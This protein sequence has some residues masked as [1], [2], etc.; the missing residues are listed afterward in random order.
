MLSRRSPVSSL[1]T[2]LVLALGE[3]YAITFFGLAYFPVTHPLPYPDPASLFSYNELSSQ[4]SGVSLRDVNELQRRVIAAASLGA[5]RYRRSSMLG[6]RGLDEVRIAEVSEG[7]FPALAVTPLLGNGF[8]QVNFSAG[9]DRELLIGVRFWKSR[10]G[11][12]RDVLGSTVD[13]G[14]KP[15]R[16]VGVIDAGSLFGSVEAWL[17]A[18]ESRDQKVLDDRSYGVIGRLKRGASLAAAQSQ[19]ERTVR[20]L[21]GNLPLLN[22]DWR[23]RIVRLDDEVAEPARRSTMMLAATSFALYL[24]SLSNAAVHM[25]GRTIE[26]ERETAIRIVLGLSLRVELARQFLRFI[27]ESA[28]GTAIALTGYL[29]MHNWLLARVPEAFSQIDQTVRLGS[30][31]GFA[32]GLCLF[33]AAFISVL[34]LLRVAAL[35]PFAVLQRRSAH[36]T[37]RGN[38]QLNSI[39]VAVQCASTVVLL[40][41]AGLMGKSAWI[42]EHQRLGFDGR[43]V[44]LARISAEGEGD[45]A[46]AA[47]AEAY[48]AALQRLGADRRFL[49][50]GASSD[51][52]LGGTDRHVVSCSLD[53]IHECEDSIYSSVSESYLQ[54]L[55]LKVSAGRPFSPDDVAAASPVAM[56][57]ASAAAKLFPGGTSVGSGISI[58]GETMRV[59]GVVPDV[60]RLGVLGYESRAALQ[61]Y[62]LHRDTASH[63]GAL[64][65]IAVR[66]DMEP[67]ET[68]MALQKDLAG[69]L[70]GARIARTRSLADLLGSV[71]LQSRKFASLL[72]LCVLFAGATTLAGVS[73]VTLLVVQGERKSAGIRL[74]FGAPQCRVV[75]GVLRPL[76]IAFVIGTALG[77]GAGYGLARL[78]ENL[79]YGVEVRD[80]AVFTILPFAFLSIATLIS[81]APARWLA[82]QDLTDLLRSE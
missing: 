66:S 70:G 39:L 16:I 59:I 11:Q 4:G 23:P 61:V 37:A 7:F 27:F 47:V 2:C 50:V 17:P 65:V 13:L 30:L 18:V 38:G 79:L 55:G 28:A 3:L 68:A 48:S 15:A 80:R 74:A 75:A 33:A 31:L 73:S 10:F 52:P 58:A 63:L 82:R 24:L 36:A 21:E 49:S 42:I 76:L 44:V 77:V 64:S 9:S 78:L 72:G 53:G 60:A 56:I 32:A 51:Y 25:L 46:S 5:Y 35:D 81:L 8:R 20:D 40:I 29:A 62:S 69:A 1:L 26:W 12:S 45:S 67:A 6:A 57:S 71:G 41:L 34:P 19:A 22:R 54:A 14:G 43:G